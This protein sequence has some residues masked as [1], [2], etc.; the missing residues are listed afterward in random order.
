MTQLV[1]FV[2]LIV[3]FVSA[4]DEGSKE[5]LVEQE[6]ALLVARQRYREA[7][8]EL[9]ELRTMIRDQAAQID[10]YRNKYLQVEWT[11]F[12]FLVFRACEQR[13]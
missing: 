12:Y 10:D 9:E 4:N 5:L 7:Q 1:S 3:T 6:Q 13:F 11:F 8:D 2:L